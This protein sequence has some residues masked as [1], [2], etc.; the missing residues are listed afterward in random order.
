MD[1]LTKYIQDQL[2]AHDLNTRVNVI[3]LSDHGMASVSPPNFIDLRQFSTEDSFKWYGSSP[4]LQIVPN[5]E[6]EL[7]QQI[8]FIFGKLSLNEFS[9]KTEELYA[10]L[11]KGAQENGHFKVYNS[12][13]LPKRWHANNKRRIGPIL[14]VA[15]MNY[16]FH[17]MFEASEDYRRK[18]N[19]SSKIF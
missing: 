18:Y 4:V 16:A 15:D 19:V 6:S 9:G 5:D 14:A 12:T 2:V 17:D 10:N 13:N 1:D 3:H 7:N 8:D 11:T